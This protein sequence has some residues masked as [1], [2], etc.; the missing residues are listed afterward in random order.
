MRERGNETER[1]I[2]THE[3]KF[4][5]RLGAHDPEPN[6]LPLEYVAASRRSPTARSAAEREAPQGRQRDPCRH[7]CR[8]YTQKQQP[9][10]LPAPLDAGRP[11]PPPNPPQVRA[12]QAPKDARPQCRS[13]RTRLTPLLLCRAGFGGGRPA[14]RPATGPPIRLAKVYRRSPNSEVP[15]MCKP[16]WV[17]PLG[18]AIGMASDLTPW[19]RKRASGHLVLRRCRSA[20][21]T[22]I[23]HGLSYTPTSLAHDCVPHRRPHSTPCFTTSATW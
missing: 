8:A 5:R 19:H 21:N 14:H 4:T 3:C 18:D 16:T 13:S 23:E 20:R 9:M 11:H 6:R 2:Y 12:L 1:N 17:R 10:C 15:K 7:S 22:T